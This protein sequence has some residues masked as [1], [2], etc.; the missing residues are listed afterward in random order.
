MRVFL[1]LTALFFAG[2]LLGWLL[3]VFWRKFF[4][5]NNPEHK[6]LNPGF[7]HGTYLPLYGFSLCLLFSLSFVRVDFIQSE[8]GQKLMLFGIMALCI[9]AMEYVG[10]IIFIKGMHIRLWDYSS[11]WG[12]LQGIICPQYTFYW[13]L[14]SAAYYFLIHPRI[15]QW[16]Y[17]FTNHLAFCL[18]IGFF[19][20]VFT[21]DLCYTLNIAAKIRTFATDHHIDVR[22][23]NLKASIQKKNEEMR[24]K[25]HF[26]FTFISERRNLTEALSESLNEVLNEVKE[27]Y[28]K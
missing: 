9:T 28:K 12:N 5:R 21:V 25:R 22:Y 20:G 8:I 18:V 10:G 1:V 3:E 14:L 11:N 16:L 15:L 7:L 19:Y 24:E 26:I 17:W 6:W 4:S 23:E 27:K 13:W 2:S